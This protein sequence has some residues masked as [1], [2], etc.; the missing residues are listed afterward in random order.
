MDLA[1][2]LIELVP[3]IP[4]ET[5][6]DWAFLV[7]LIPMAVR[8]ILLYKPYT[9]FSS[10]FPEKRKEAFTLVRRLKIPGFEQFLRHQAA[11]ILLPGLIAL[12]ILTYWGLDHLIWEDLPS[13]VAALGSV[14]LFIWVFTEIDRAYRVSKKLDNAVIDLN[15]ILEMIKEK[16]PF[17]L[18]KSRLDNFSQTLPTL[19][20]LVKIREGIQS[21]TSWGEPKSS[22]TNLFPFIGTLGKEISSII[23]EMVKIPQ[24]AAKELITSL[25]KDLTTSI[26]KKLDGWFKPY[27][28]S[29]KKGTAILILRSAAPSIWLGFLVWY[30]GIAV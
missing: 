26:D 6:R 28:S 21:T 30:T 29:T 8:L 12:P 20:F 1:T 23:H 5:I 3:S 13:D 25:S 22:E 17:A 2:F 18:A 9:E 27:I 19:G 7:I 11:I 16:I 15:N 4:P 24:D 14:G 10:L